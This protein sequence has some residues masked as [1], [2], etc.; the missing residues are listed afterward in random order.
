MPV[1][2]GSTW[3]IAT[4]RVEN[5]GK[6]WFEPLTLAVAQNAKNK[7]RMVEAERVPDPHKYRLGRPVPRREDA[8][9]DPPQGPRGYIRAAEGR[10]RCDRQ[11]ILSRR[12]PFGGHDQG[13]VEDSAAPANPKNGA[14]RTATQLEVQNTGERTVDAV[15]HATFRAPKGV[16]TLLTIRV[17]PQEKKLWLV[18]EVPGG[19]R[20]RGPM[21][22]SRSSSSWIGVRSSRGGGGLAPRVEVGLAP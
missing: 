1:G 18:S 19:P 16:E 5:F 17:N 13:P 8:L 15:F 6:S 22:T 2:G 11:T 14:L 4:V 10:V 7:G 3:S 12:L 20:V 21:P 9:R